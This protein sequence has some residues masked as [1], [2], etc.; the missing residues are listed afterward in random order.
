MGQV[1]NLEKRVYHL[2]TKDTKKE[3][4]LAKSFKSSDEVME[5][6]A[7]GSGSGRI[8]SKN[9]SKRFYH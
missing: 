6:K 2:G 7:G 1:Q 4:I 8:E 5:R 9:Q 3:L